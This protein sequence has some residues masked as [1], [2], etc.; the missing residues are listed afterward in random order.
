M[1]Q[2]TILSPHR[3]DAVFSLSI[4]LSRWRELTLAMK[5]VNFFTKSEYGPHS[6]SNRVASIS[7]L[8]SKEDR[9]VLASIDKR[10]RVESLDLL[11][12]PIRLG[13]SANAICEEATIKLQR[14]EEIDALSTRIQKY[15]SV[16]LVLAPL[17][18]GNHVD[19]LL[20]SKSAV[21]AS[22]GGQKLAFYEDLPYATWISEACLRKRLLCIER[23][24]NIQLRPKSVCAGRNAVRHKFRRIRRYESQ[25]TREEARAMSQYAVRYRG[26]ERIW[27][28]KYSNCWRF[29]FQ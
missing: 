21:A 22:P 9:S 27:I 17:A 5:V 23:K 11:D 18:L 14:Q 12:A 13:I 1:R 15:F 10:I 20:I 25:I 8:R 7:A 2:L 4:A 28:P 3:D 26:G 24:L 29:L 16:G 19:H 6:L